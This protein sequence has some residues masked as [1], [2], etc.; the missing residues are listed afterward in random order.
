VLFIPVV[1]IFII[2]I[3]I[4][5]VGVIIIMEHSRPTDKVFYIEFDSWPPRRTYC[6]VGV[7]SL[8]SRA[9][10]EQSA[11]SDYI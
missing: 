8:T 7:C 2:I 4:I 1:I 9:I 5:V 6:V 3:I 10:L 11:D